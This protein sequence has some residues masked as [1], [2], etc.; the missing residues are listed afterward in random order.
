MPGGLFPSAAT[1]DHPMPSKPL[2]DD[3]PLILDRV[4][5]L[6]Q[7]MSTE[8]FL[9]ILYDVA[10]DLVQEGTDIDQVASMCERICAKLAIRVN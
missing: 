4:A 1:A 5:A 6:A 7:N 3:L 8:E 10:A 9:T 2:D